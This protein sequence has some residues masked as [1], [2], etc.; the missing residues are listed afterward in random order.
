[1]DYQVLLIVLS[2]IL[3]LPPYPTFT[4]LVEAV[5]SFPL[6]DFSLN[7]FI[8]CHIVARVDSHAWI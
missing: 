8:Y 1:M 2:D 3:I 6:L 5:F 4:S 7:P